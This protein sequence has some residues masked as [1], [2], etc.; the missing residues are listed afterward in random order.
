MFTYPGTITLSERTLTFLARLLETH[1]EQRR[2]WR[3]LSASN[4]AL[5]VLAHLRNGDTY[6]R[7]AVGFGVG[8]ATVY[9]YV[10]EAV[11]LLAALGRSLT[12]ALW[13]LAWTYSNFALLDGPVVRTNRVR[14]ADRRYYACRH[15][16]HGMNL[17]GVTDPQGRLIWIVDGLPGSTHDLSAARAY[18]VF[19]VAD[20]AQ[21][22][23]YADK[24]YIGGKGA[25]LLTSYK[26][27]NLP[28]SYRE[29]NCCHAAV[30]AN[31]ERGFA[32]L[33]SWK[34]FDRFFGCPRQVGAFAR[35]VLTLEHGS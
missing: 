12:A 24:G 22:Y 19:G 14:A 33:K 28:D 9:R 6:Q 3:K 13:A 20:R 21:L 5:R 10:R 4:Q 7:L 11:A 26:G 34:I 35:A 25:T 2:T 30:R 27:Q 18:G 8:L 15:K 31:G 32:V 29:A 16:H 17:Q 23:L 1:R